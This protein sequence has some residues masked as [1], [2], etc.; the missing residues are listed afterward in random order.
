MKPFN[1]HVG[2]QGVAGAKGKAKTLSVRR[3]FNYN[4]LPLLMQDKKVKWVI[5]AVKVQNIE[6][7]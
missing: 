2:P 5:L 1:W 4:M 7:V 3:L 6:H